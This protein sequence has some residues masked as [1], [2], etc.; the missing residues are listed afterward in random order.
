MDQPSDKEQNNS[1]TVEFNGKKLTIPPE[2]IKGLESIEAGA[3]PTMITRRL[4]FFL[5]ELGLYQTSM[6]PEQAWRT[7]Q[8]VAQRVPI[9][10]PAPAPDLA[11]A[12]DVPPPPPPLEFKPGAGGLTARIRRKNKGGR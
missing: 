12:P 5:T 8:Q 6:T 4:E 7:L 1:N 3:F 2:L 9:T 11:P 10:P